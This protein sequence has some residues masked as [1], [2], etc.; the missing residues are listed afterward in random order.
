M[1]ESGDKNK[2]IL[3]P[4]RWLTADASSTSTSRSPP[5]VSGLGRCSGR[6][7]VNT[8]THVSVGSLCIL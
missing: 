4:N 5:D 7:L 6:A 2:I 3:S 8:P 1:G